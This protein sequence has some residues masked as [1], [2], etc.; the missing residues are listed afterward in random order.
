MSSQASS[1]PCQVDGLLKIYIH[2]TH[3]VFLEF[4][5]QQK[6]QKAKDAFTSHV[7]DPTLNLNE[8]TRP[9]HTEFVF[10]VSADT[11]IK[12]VGELIHHVTAVITTE[13]SL[14]KNVPII[15]ITMEDLI[16]EG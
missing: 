6:L 1:I 4:K 15:F 10:G 8:S 12:P 16:Y 9:K 14:K 3:N 13:T 5:N 2:T 7:I 11:S